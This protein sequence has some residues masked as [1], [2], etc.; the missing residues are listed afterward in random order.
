MCRVYFVNIGTYIVRIQCADITVY[1]YLSVEPPTHAYSHDTAN[2]L[3]VS[4]RLMTYGI[5]SPTQGTS[6]Q[7]G[8]PAQQQSIWIQ[9]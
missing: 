4:R 2:V 1:H 9:Q 7:Q 5:F 3:P 6:T 8:T